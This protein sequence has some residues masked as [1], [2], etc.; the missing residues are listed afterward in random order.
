[1][2]IGIS[3][4]SIANAQDNLNKETGSAWDF[5]AVKT[6]ADTTWNQRLHAIEVTS[7]D[8]VALT[9]FYTAFYHTL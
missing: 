9:K 3:Y 6:A 7:T 4:V 8:P 5:D 2:K 1:M